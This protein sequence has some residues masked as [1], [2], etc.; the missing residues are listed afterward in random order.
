MVESHRLMCS[1]AWSQVGSTI[2]EDYGTFNFLL[3]GYFSMLTEKKLIV[4]HVVQERRLR[5]G[6]VHGP[7]SILLSA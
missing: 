4:E 1:K 3:P 6:D 2:W 7:V 5:G